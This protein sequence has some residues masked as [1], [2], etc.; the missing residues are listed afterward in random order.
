MT[1]QIVIHVTEITQEK[2]TWLIQDEQGNIVQKSQQ[3]SL[4]E[5]TKHASDKTVIVLF[6]SQNIHLYY[7]DIPKTSQDKLQKVIPYALE[8]HLASDLNHLHFAF[9]KRNDKGLIPTVVI[10]KKILAELLKKFQEAQL[11]IEYCIPDIFGL[12]KGQWLALLIQ[13][14]AY[15]N[16][17]N[18]QQ[19]LISKASLPLLLAQANPE[20][21]Q[22]LILKA[23]KTEA[24]D[25]IEKN[26]QNLNLNIEVQTLAETLLD[27]FAQH[28][29][30]NEAINLLQNEFKTEHKSKL[31][32]KYWLLPTS[33][34]V[35]LIVLFTFLQVASLF[36]LQHKENQ[37]T[38][39]INAIYKDLFP[40]ATQIISPRLRVQ[41]ELTRLKNRSLGTGFLPILAN[42]SPLIKENQFKILNLEYRNQRLLIGIQAKDFQSLQKFKDQ[43]Q[44]LKLQIKQSNATT[45][46]K[47]VKANFEVK[48]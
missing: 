37:L 17:P 33:M 5:I 10:E 2:Y 48:R 39:K 31:L 27:Y 12:E 22:T 24:A 42:I 15:L 43:V 3:N 32:K 28:L 23:Q 11:T 26:I 21:K 16:I 40:D 19:C 30:L 45:A 41:R 44:G 4:A 18:Q 46:G 14:Q 34:T 20:Y 47:Q 1:Q 38:T 25:A 6:S 13:D 7:A 35:A 36:Y 8:E 29:K 9:G